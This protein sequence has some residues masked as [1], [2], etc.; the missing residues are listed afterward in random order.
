[1]DVLLDDHEIDRFEAPHNPSRNTHGSGCAL[2]AAITARLARGETLH[3]AVL[4]A[5]AF[6]TEAIRTAPGLGSGVAGPTN[7]HADAGR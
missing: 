6:V 5:K 1:M 2:S 4:A 7:L 3:A